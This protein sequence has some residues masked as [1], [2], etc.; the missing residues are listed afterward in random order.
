LPGGIERAIVNL[1]NLFAEKQN[2]VS[3]VILDETSESF[4]PIHASVA[5]VQEAL[6]F[7]IGKDGN[8]VSRKISLLTDVLKLRRIIK[9]L[10]PSLVI[11]TEYPFA[12][13]AIL[14]G[15]KRT[16]KVISW[17][18]HHFNYLKKSQFWSSLYNLAYPRLNAV[19]CLNAREANYFQK[20]KRTA[21]IPNF[22]QNTTGKRSSL[23]SKTILSVGWLIPR[24]GI[25]L[26]LAAAKQILKDQPAWKW[27]LIGTGEMENEVLQFIAKENLEGRFI[28][29]APVNFELDKEYLNASLFALTSR[30]EAFPMVL[31]EA[32]S[33]GV[34]CVSF[35]CPTGPADIINNSEDGLI[36]ENDKPSELAKA[37]STLVADNEMRKKMGDNAI[38]NVQ[39]FSPEK[40][41][42]LWQEFFL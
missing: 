34:P 32:L 9:T 4:Y 31:L 3:L 5:V 13:A 19:V 41:Y 20:F 28:L 15:T 38:E 17:E 2:R 11:C 18:H 30:F 36:V 40:I 26:M 16:S 37:L 12:V 22:V 8:I 42:Q 7:G 1:S 10:A 27:K 29:Q 6:S 24:K 33:F 35:D 21:V 25:D 39:R 23:E 14:S